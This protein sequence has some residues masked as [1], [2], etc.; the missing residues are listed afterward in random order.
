MFWKI[1]TDVDI[2]TDAFSRSSIFETIS[3]SASSF[4]M[5]WEVALHRFSGISKKL[6]KEQTDEL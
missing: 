2:L 5:F 4:F 6:L 1:C 3:D